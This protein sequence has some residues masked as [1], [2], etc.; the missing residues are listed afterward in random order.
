MLT[1]I[2]LTYTIIDVMRDNLFDYTPIKVND[3]NCMDLVVIL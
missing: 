1:A 3:K 2:T